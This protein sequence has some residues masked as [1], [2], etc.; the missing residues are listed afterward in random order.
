MVSLTAEQQVSLPMLKVGWLHQTFVHW[1]YDPAAVQALLPSGLTVDTYDD[2]AWVSLTPFLMSRL[3]MPGLPATA[4]ASFPETNLR[5][6]VR[7]PDGRDALWFLSIEVSSAVM[8]TAHAIGVPYYVGDLSL[9]VGED[10]TVAYAGTRR[11]G[12][13]SYRL[14]V[15]PGTPIAA[16][17]RDLWLTSRW[18]AAT[19]RAGRLWEVPVDHEPWP[20][21]TVGIEEFQQSLLRAAALPPAAGEPLAHFSEGV[22]RVR[23]G[24]PRRV[25]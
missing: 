3:R 19:R 16:E 15:R 21:A 9:H 17:E 24:V 18:R 13:P 7:L 10:G 22:H 25:R 12:E 5:T 11:G 2:A 4:L 20:L 14:T 6:Y 1:P 23:L 8:L